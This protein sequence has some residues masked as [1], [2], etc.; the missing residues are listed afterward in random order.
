M[1][2]EERRFSSRSSQLR[3]RPLTPDPEERT[4]VLNHHGASSIFT[5]LQRDGPVEMAVLKRK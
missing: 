3:L 5:A 4:G 1:P 2:Q